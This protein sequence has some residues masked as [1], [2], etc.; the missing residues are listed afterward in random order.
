MEYT[1]LEPPDN[2]IVFHT[3]GHIAHQLPAIEFTHEGKV[4]KVYWDGTSFHFDQPVQMDGMNEM[5]HEMEELDKKLNEMDKKIDVLM[6]HILY[7][8]GGDGYKKAEREFSIV[9]SRGVGYSTQTLPTDDKLGPPVPL[10][11][12][13]VPLDEPLDLLTK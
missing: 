6:N 12:D 13:P 1:L 9:A 4:G 11:P 2:D 10:L 7:R 3:T 8:P 5:K